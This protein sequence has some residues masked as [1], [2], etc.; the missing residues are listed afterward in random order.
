MENINL[1]LQKRSYNYSFTYKDV[2]YTADII[3]DFYS[4]TTELKIYSKDN[5]LVTGALAPCLNMVH[6]DYVAKTLDSHYGFYLSLF[7]V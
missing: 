6:G 3:V 5:K 4:K 2:E 7:G 1:N